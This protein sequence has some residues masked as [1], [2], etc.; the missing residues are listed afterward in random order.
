VAGAV[1]VG[2]LL[3]V[4]AVQGWLLRRAIATQPGW[5][6]EFAEF[7]VGPGGVEARG[8]DFAMPGVA[9]K[10]EPLVVRIAPGRLFTKR[11]LRVERAE[12]QKVR[13]VVTPAELAVDETAGPFSGLLNLLQLP[14]P[15]ALDQA[16]IEGEIAVR[17]GGS[18][19]VVG[20]FKI[21]GG[22]VEAERTGEF[23][24]E[25]AI[26]SALLP[27][28]PENKVRSRGKVRLAQTA[29]HGVARIDVEGDLVLP[30]YGRLALP[31]GKFNLSVAASAK[32]EAYS[33]HLE[34]GGGA[35]VELHGSLDAATATLA[36]RLEVQG[37]QSLAAS[38]VGERVPDVAAQ[39]G[40]DFNVDLRS[41]DFIA[42]AAGEFATHAWEKFA[43]ELAGVDAFKGNVN[44]TVAKRG[45][46]LLLES[47]SV[48]VRGDRLQ[49]GSYLGAEP[50]EVGVMLTAPVDLLKLPETPL[51]TIAMEHWPVAWAN[52]W[53][54]DSG[55][56]LSNAEFGGE[57]SAALS[58]QRGLTV[59]PVKSCT[60]SAVTAKGEKLPPIPPVTFTFSPVLQ[61]SAE[62]AAI[63][64]KN[65]AIVAEKGDKVAARVVADYQFASGALHSAGRVRGAL[66]TLLSGADKPLP[67]SLT[68]HWDATLT[69]DR[70]RVQVLEFMARKRAITDPFFAVQLLQPLTVDVNT[71]KATG[72]H[73]AAGDWVKLKFQELQLGWISRWIP[74]YTFDGAVTEGESVLRSAGDGGLTFVPVKPW[75]IAQASFAIGGRA[76]FEGELKVTPAFEVSAEKC[77][78]ELG[79]LL[80]QGRDGTRLSG[81]VAFE[82]DLKN[83]R[84]SS[85]LE[86]EADL[87]ALPHSEGTFGA[88][89]ATL[90]AK[91]HNETATIAAFDEFALRVR[92]RERELLAVEATQPFL[93]GLS[94]S[95]MFTAASLAP[96]R[97]TTGEIPLAWLRPW[98]G[99][100][101]MEGALQPSEFVLT[102]KLT[103]F[104]LRPIRPVQVK[105]FAA[106]FGGRELARD[107][108]L[109]L[110]PGLDLTFICVPL[111]TF[112]LAYSGTAH[113]TDVAIDIGGERAFDLDAALSFLGNDERMLPSG[114][115]LATRVDFAPFAKLPALAGRGLPTRGSFVARV[116]GDMLGKEPLEHWARIEGVPSRD[117]K[118][119]LPALEILA[120][121]K[122]SPA[123]SQF[124]GDVSVRLETKPR[125]TD[126]S[127]EV[128][129]TLGGDRLEIGSTLHSAYFNAGEM[130]ELVS[131]FEP[132]A[133]GG[134]R[135]KADGA[136]ERRGRE[137]PPYKS[138]GTPFWSAIRGRF[139][140]DLGA[141]EFAP[142]RIEKLRGRLDAR[143]REL[144]LSGLNGEMFAGR[145]QGDLRI[146]Y[147]PERTDGDHSLAGEF[148]IQQFDSARVV[149]TV[150]P[151]ELAS[152]DARI[153]VNST[154]RSRG[155]AVF[156]LI[157][158]AE[159][160]FT[161]EGKQGVVRLQVP[162]QDVA[163]TAAVFGWT[164]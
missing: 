6:V 18:E 45:A 48:V 69:G 24:Y 117:G 72:D 35:S 67:F 134:E 64:V 52:S 83:K 92:N 102:A 8:L 121:G 47:A 112:T 39:G 159:A 132:Q 41:G 154:V 142:D 55:V 58:A 1:G 156:E 133:V 25:I 161:V 74:G 118:R 152:V 5:R 84:G 105:E 139:D 155:N 98:S 164:R 107:T 76:L 89:N 65:F 32:G 144:V 151:N 131:A 160:A 110:Y 62:R 124:L 12:A 130:L 33:G 23:S 87:P 36:G 99:A 113:L 37:N 88:V 73:G 46:T 20:V 44:A 146:D 108:Q 60:I 162:K 97:V 61:V 145:W 43:P 103:K 22:H 26:N 21:E 51:A 4:P 14:M 141:V 90:R 120:H 91:S 80:A 86:L 136:V 81:R 16:K 149:Q 77:T 30:H 129:G 116:N 163:A 49:A 101:E 66:P 148:K 153:D 115:E 68:A 40:V 50:A 128:T 93:V 10:V 106:R 2:A 123:N 34:L 3:L 42:K 27:L 54:K 11:E 114:L 137:T 78:A 53:L 135:A 158:R 95:G 17:D 57:W 82:A 31:A 75:R 138:S 7:G 28:G 70:L 19:V 15:W 157:D 126:A 56:A 59:T 100:L 122:V 85:A 96:L 147:D 119:T 109:T 63:D 111:P 150:F 127:F 94:N 104:F 38:A 13:V 9:A 125:A 140:L 29:A 71:W 79:G 143:D